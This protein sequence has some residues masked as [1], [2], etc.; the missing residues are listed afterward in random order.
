MAWSA[1]HFFAF[2]ATDFSSF[3]MNQ[4]YKLSC[5]SITFIPSFKYVTVSPCFALHILT[6]SQP[7]RVL[8]HLIKFKFLWLSNNKL[9]F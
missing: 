9:W 1:V 6:I 7:I 2:Y 3:Y 8:G 5:K 4:K